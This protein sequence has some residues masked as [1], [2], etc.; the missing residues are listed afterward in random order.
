MRLPKL[1]IENYQFTLIVVI[2]LVMSGVVSFMGMPRTEDPPVAKP[3]ATIVVLY[4]GATPSDME[5]LVVTPLEEAIN[6]LEDIKRLEST[7]EDGLALLQTEF[8]FGSDPDEKFSDINEKVN[9]IRDDLP[10]DI[11]KL[12]TIKWT[13]EDTHFLQVALVSDQADYRTLE[14][15]AED[16]KRS[17]EKIAGV[18]RVKTWAHPAQQVRIVLDL[19]KLAQARIPLGRVMGAIE[20]ANLNIPG[21]TIDAGKKRFNIE[22]SGP[23]ASLGEIEDTVIHTDGGKV[24]YLRDLAEVVLGHEDE[25]HIGR[26]D[27]RRAVFVTASQKRNTNIFPIVERVHAVLATFEKTL[28]GTMNLVTVYNQAGGVRSRLNGFFLN[29]LQGIFLV[30][31]VILLTIGPRG[32]LIVMLAIPISLF[33]GIGFVDLSG[34]GIQQMTIAGLV[35]TLGLLV[36]NAIVVTENISRFIRLGEDKRRAALL[37]AGQIAWAIVSA[38]ATTILAFVPL[39]T[40]QDVSGEY[41]RSM[42]LTVIFILAASLF[43]ALT[44]TPYLSVKILRPQQDRRDTRFQRWLNGFIENR[45]ARMLDFSLRRPYRVIGGALVVFLLSL[46]LFPLVGVSFFPKAEKK[47]FFIDVSLPEGTAIQE[48]DRV[49]REV[50]SNLAGRTGIVHVAANVGHSNPRI[51]Y[52]LIEKQGKAN[53]AQIFVQLSEDVSRVEMARIIA[54]LRADFSATPGARIEVKELEQGPPVQ[55]PVEIKIRGRN[56]EM[57]ERIA[58]DI[59]SLFRQVPGL[60][61]IN[62]PLATS[63]SDI[64]VVIHRDKAAMLGI[65][66]HEIDRTIRMSIA[67]LTVSTYRDLE[68][69]AYDIVLRAANGERPTM[70]IFGRI[71]VTS[72]TGVQIPLTQV[73]SVALQSSPVRIDHFNMERSVTLTADVRPGE[74]VNRLTARLLD[75]LDRYR[76]PV[77]YT[78]HVGGEKEGQEE[79]FG[80]MGQAVIVAIIA[81]FAVLVLQFRSFSQPLVVFSALPLAVIGSIL[82]LLITGYTFSFTAFVGLTSLV[83][84]VVNNS[85]ILVD[86][87]NQLRREGRDTLAAVREAGKTRFTP[88]IL[89]TA[90]TVGGLLPLTLG[91]GT[92]W[93]PMGWTIIGGLITSTFLTLILVPVLYRMFTRNGGNGEGA[94]AP[95]S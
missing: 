2:L 56:V 12:Q 46:A 22:T 83:G 3:G 16:L 50:E 31:V 8:Y 28:P 81:I 11:L 47:Q 70:D 9:S 14:S 74:S 91:G 65:P 42:P 63:K 61:N 10:R 51:Y 84:I 79:S 93:A 64:Q 52:N 36:D 88:I 27:L 69:K 75:S 80:G 7:C 39:V 72:A 54:Q 41:I 29:L 5:E 24:I 85:I 67:G 82:A 13:I 90:T 21:G 76:W 33:I 17:L 25:K 94:V 6:E 32:S 53:F 86:Y 38:T 89:T 26:L 43:I 87:S 62:N 49:T 20:S 68:G 95:V 59:E 15:K 66:L 92:L 1:A 18:R 44:F 71:H 37:G 78:Y 45:Y 34:Y 73:A 19:E 57:L 60:I 48:T 4:P 23:F 30:G 40:M 58:F 55:A 77:G 35:I